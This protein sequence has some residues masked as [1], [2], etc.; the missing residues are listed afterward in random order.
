LPG[1]IE[2]RL[3]RIDPL[4]VALVA[5]L[6]IAALVVWSTV[7]ERVVSPVDGWVTERVCATHGERIGREVTGYEQSNRFGLRNRSEGF[8]RYGIGPNGEAPITLTVAEAE[9]GL[10]YRATKWLGIIFQLGVVSLFL[11]FT[12]DPVFEVARFLRRL[13]GRLG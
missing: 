7:R 1:P 3:K 10:R 12:V 2:D 9:P 4:R 13:V 11:R 8:C 5:L 6:L